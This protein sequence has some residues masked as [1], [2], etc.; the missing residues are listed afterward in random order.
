MGS[1]VVEALVQQVAKRKTNP[2]EVSPEVS[3]P[4]TQS[5]FELEKEFLPIEQKVVRTAR[6]S[7]LAPSTALSRPITQSSSIETAEGYEG[8]LEQKNVETADGI[9]GPIEQFELTTA[10]PT[11]TR[12][13]EQRDARRATIDGGPIEQEEQISNSIDIEQFDFLD[14]IF[15]PC[16]SIRNPVDTNLLVRITDF[17]FT[18]NLATLVFKVNGIEVQDDPEFVTT[19]LVNG[20]QL[21]YNPPE[22]FAYSSEV[23]IFIE[24]LDTAPVPNRFVFRCSFF[25]VDDTIGPRVENF[26]LCN[27]TNVDARAPVVFDV[28]DF[29][30]GVNADSIRLNIEGIGVCSGI[31]LTELT[32]SSGNGFRVTW[33]HASAPF[34]FG[35]S[36]TA[37]VTAEDNALEPNST[38]FICRFEVEDS[39]A[40]QF[41][42]FSPGPCKSFIDNT[43]GLTF[44][45]YGIEDGVDISTLEVVVDSKDRKV[46]VRPR[47]RRFE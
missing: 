29:E 39:S 18:F 1:Q 4:I 10:G 34:R 12:I 16:N 28:V 13:I 37:A 46:L 33:N 40:P 6:S 9:E 45:V 21:D 31:A 38:L 43:T 3:N 14:L 11:F 19:P 42:N 8:T 20:A 17:G 47:V 22:N 26:S 36:V 32:T 27:T 2:D 23:R 7:P 5:P 44:E 41:I 24:V 35:S 25:T 15:P 30:T